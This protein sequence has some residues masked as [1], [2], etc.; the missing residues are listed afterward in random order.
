MVHHWHLHCVWSV[1]FRF[2]DIK[3][4][5]DAFLSETKDVF[6]REFEEPYDRVALINLMIALP[7]QS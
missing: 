1:Y 3:H 2:S 6:I 7:H 5:Y 4:E